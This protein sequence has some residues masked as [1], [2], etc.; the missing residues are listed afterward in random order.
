M[1]QSHTEYAGEAPLNRLSL[2]SGGLAQR[3][4]S[5]MQR[6]SSAL[7]SSS[8]EKQSWFMP[9]PDND[10]NCITRVLVIQNS[11]ENDANTVI[12][13]DEPLD[14]DYVFHN[15]TPYSISFQC[16]DGVGKQDLGLE[17]MV[18]SGMKKCFVWDD[19]QIKQLLLRVKIGREE[20]M[21]DFTVNEKVERKLGISYDDH[22][23][24]YKLEIL[25]HGTKT[26][27]VEVN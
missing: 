24:N 18:E 11:L 6:F 14:E 25:P 3:Q 12:I 23:F 13:F 9:G 5:L 26:I 21:I 16:Y 27:T 17:S 15:N 2:D 10:F 1:K 8:R 20:G 19:R 4:P 7:N 22:N